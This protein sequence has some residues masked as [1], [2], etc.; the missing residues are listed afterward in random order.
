LALAAA[1]PAMAANPDVPKHWYMM[2]PFHGT[3][4]PSVF[5]IDVAG[6]VKSYAGLIE[7]VHDHT[8]DIA[9]VIV[10]DKR[11]LDVTIVL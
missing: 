7:V 6:I 8:G 10:R 11:S 5:T 1:S 9:M 3:C 4:D 2:D